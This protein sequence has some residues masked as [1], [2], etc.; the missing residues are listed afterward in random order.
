MQRIQFRMRYQT[1][2]QLFKLTHLASNLL[3]APGNGGGSQC[4]PVEEIDYLGFTLRNHY[5]LFVKISMDHAISMNELDRSNDT[6]PNLGEL[7]QGKRHSFQS[8]THRLAWKQFHN[9]GV[10][11]TLSL[12][13]I[14]FFD[15]VNDYNV[16]MLGTC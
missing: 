16:L 2:K 3:V 15:S 9:N 5:V 14:N 6:S 11:F 7:I 1:Q 4:V 8:F 10:Y 12:W 13:I